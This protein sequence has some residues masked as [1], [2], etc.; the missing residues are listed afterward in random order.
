MIENKLSALLSK[1]CNIQKLFYCPLIQFDIKPRP[2]IRLYKKGWIMLLISPVPAAQ[3]LPVQLVKTTNQSN[4]SADQEEERDTHWIIDRQTGR[5]KLLDCYCL[6]AQKPKHIMTNNSI[7]NLLR[8][9]RLFAMLVDKTLYYWGFI[10]MYLSYPA[11]L[12]LYISQDCQPTCWPDWP[13]L[14]TSSGCS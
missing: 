3:P 8:C 9:V 13:S 6:I 10:K 4:Q 12:C 7:R 1:F 11:D 5:I 14:V 2:Y